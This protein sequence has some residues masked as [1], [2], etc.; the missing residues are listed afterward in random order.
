LASFKKEILKEFIEL[1]LVEKKQTIGISH[2]T[3]PDFLVVQSTGK[4]DKIATAAKNLFQAVR[5]LIGG[6][7]GMIGSIV[8]T[9]EAFAKLA[10]NGVGKLFGDKS[11]VDDILI[12]Q[13]ESLMK[14]RG[15]SGKIAGTPGGA[16][17]MKEALLILERDE[18]I[19]A[20]AAEIVSSAE[21]DVSSFVS[22][23]KSIQSGEGDLE[24]NLLTIA[25]MFGDG[26][27]PSEVSALFDPAAAERLEGGKI[28]PED[29]SKIKGSVSNDILAKI[30]PQA[31]K[32][33]L[34]DAASAITKEASTLPK[35]AATPV[36]AGLDK[37]YSDAI[38]QF[39]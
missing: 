28:S 17:T 27:L 25:S 18:A 1:S 13:R 23:M 19:S 37:I 2:Y 5:E 29:M 12:S 31:A 10:F 8:S 22:I 4:W 24:S 3:P 6:V 11:K 36:V 16:K 39:E 20:G 21:R 7:V 34:S 38:S 14:I 30:V 26:T 9:G 35:D 33:Y 15:I 32:K